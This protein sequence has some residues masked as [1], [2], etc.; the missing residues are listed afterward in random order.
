MKL[1]VISNPTSIPNEVAIINALLDE[2]LE[3]FHVR[4]P[5]LNMKDTIDFLLG[6]KTE[7]REKLVMHDHHSIASKIGTK[8]IHFSGEK[9]MYTPE[10][11]LK[12]WRS[13]NYTLSTSV[14]SVE[15][16]SELS[17]HFHYTFLGP[18]FESISKPGYKPM[19]AFD[20][21]EK[22]NTQIFAIGGITPDKLNDAALSKFDGA[23]LLG[24]IWQDPDNAI[25]TFQHARRT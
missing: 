7:H 11:D 1:I 16:Y 4:K 24:T 9:R 13:K 23:T 8:R 6:I 18:V 12:Q 20:L 22:R 14:H 5:G 25:K 19:H 10:H 17:P 2:G 3:I 21:P 15:E